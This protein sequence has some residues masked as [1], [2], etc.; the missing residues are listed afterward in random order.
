MK[1]KNIKSISQVIVTI[2][3]VILV[4]GLTPGVI[5][6]VYAAPSDKSITAFNFASPAAIGTINESVHT[7]TIN[8]PFGTNVTALAP[9][10]TH[11]GLSISPASGVPQDFTN[12]VTYSVTA[13]D[14]SMQNYTVSV[15]IPITV[16]AIPGQNKVYGGGDPV[17]TYTSSNFVPFTGALDRVPGESVGSYA[18]GR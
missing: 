5:R 14:F 3:L 12:P 16:T 18:I 17:F 15:V 6:P 10:I 9:T 8:V 1:S 7:I 4:A 2:I 11:N 13:A